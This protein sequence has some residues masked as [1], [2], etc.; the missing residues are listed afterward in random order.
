[1]NHTLEERVHEE[2]LSFLELL[3]WLAL[4]GLTGLVCG[5]AGA[6]FSHVL[7]A[8]DRKSVV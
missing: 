6:A 8:V 5:L 3:R 7:T 2:E 1:M 4:A